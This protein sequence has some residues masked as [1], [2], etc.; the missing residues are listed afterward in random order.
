MVKATRPVLRGVSEPVT[1]LWGGN[2]PRLPDWDEIRHRISSNVKT[3]MTRI[4][5]WHFI[6]KVMSV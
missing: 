6:I 2:T 1:A 5:M 4:S 3:P